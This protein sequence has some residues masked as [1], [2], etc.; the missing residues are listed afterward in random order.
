M[1]Q[2]QSKESRIVGPAVQICISPLGELQQANDREGWRGG[3]S[4]LGL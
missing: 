2:E 1:F 3:C 4:G